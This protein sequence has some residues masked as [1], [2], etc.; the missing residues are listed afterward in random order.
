MVV[1]AGGGCHGGDG[2]GGDA[3]SGAG[4]GASV[5]AGTGSAVALVLLPK[6]MLPLSMKAVVGRVGLCSGL[7]WGRAVR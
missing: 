3:D 4:A 7:S 6:R 2:G 5:G 1:A